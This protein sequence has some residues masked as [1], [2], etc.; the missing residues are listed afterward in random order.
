MWI[1][2]ARDIQVVAEDGLNNKSKKAKSS[3]AFYEIDAKLFAGWYV[4]SGQ[5]KRY[6]KLIMKDKKG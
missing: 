3:D 5:R 4:F 6:L 1:Y 2:W